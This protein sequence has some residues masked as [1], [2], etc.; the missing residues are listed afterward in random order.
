MISFDS[1]LPK[2]KNKEVGIFS[3]SFFSSQRLLIWF[4]FV[5]TYDIGLILFLSVK[6]GFTF[7][8]NI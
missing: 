3:S 2:E 1:P 8:E 6:T 5:W 4:C 7:S